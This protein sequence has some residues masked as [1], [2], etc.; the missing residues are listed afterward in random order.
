MANF[1]G[2]V[3][4]LLFYFQAYKIFSTQ[5]ACSVSLVGFSISLISL[6]SWL[7]YGFLT[8]SKVMIVA[9]IAGLIGCVW[10]LIGIMMY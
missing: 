4:Q 8:K 5:S 3:G 2:I 10:V 9:N 1:I 6:I 7:F